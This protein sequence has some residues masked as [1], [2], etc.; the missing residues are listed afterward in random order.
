MA[1]GGANDW[2][3]HA[4]HRTSLTGQYDMASARMTLEEERRQLRYRLHEIE[5]ELA[6]IEA[7][8]EINGRL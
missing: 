1:M 8:Q 3:R 6:K 4:M 5:A 7:A 2:L